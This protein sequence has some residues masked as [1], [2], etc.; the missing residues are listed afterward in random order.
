MSRFSDFLSLAMLLASSAAANAASAVDAPSASSAVEAKAPAE[1]RSRFYFTFENDLL[2]RPPSDTN[3]TM[4]VRMSWVNSGSDERNG[5]VD[6]SPLRQPVE[7][8]RDH[9]WLLGG[10]RD[11]A[12]RPSRIV[13]FADDAFTPAC[14]HSTTVCSAQGHP[15]D[16]DRPYANIIYYSFAL[17]A[18]PGDLQDGYS[19]E[20]AVGLVGTAIGRDVQTWIHERCCRDKIPQEWHTQIGQSATGVPTLLYKQL[21]RHQVWRTRDWSGIDVEARYGFWAGWYTWP[22]VGLEAKT[23]WASVALDAS[24]VLHNEF[25]QGAYAGR[26]DI[27][28]RYGQLEHEVALGHADINLVALA[29]DLIDIGGANPTPQRWGLSYSQG[30]K[31]R[32][33]KV[34]G[35]ERRHRWGGLTLWFNY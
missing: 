27:R 33:L 18:T 23:R 25:L 14:L 4:G 10:R 13:N 7:Y 24:Y 34:P 29:S 5:D 16:Q 17:S 28:Y 15:I 21:R 3:Y 9:M 6:A 12:N 32:E 8:A 2:A 31:S 26:S 22:T 35:V 11:T 1:M 20:L 19:T 30:W